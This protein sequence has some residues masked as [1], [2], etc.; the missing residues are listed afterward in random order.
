MELFS[1]LPHTQVSQYLYQLRKSRNHDLGLFEYW[2]EHSR[3][4]IDPVIDLAGSV[5][6]T[7]SASE[8]LIG[9]F[10][11]LRC[12]IIQARGTFI[13]SPDSLIETVCAIKQ[14]TSS[15]M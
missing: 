11:K 13:E 10:G 5:G 9:A 3:E 1:L 12:T 14:R 4:L 15:I 6:E 2:D 7:A 8:Q